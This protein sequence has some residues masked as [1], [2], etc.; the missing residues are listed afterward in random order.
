MSIVDRLF[1]GRVIKDYGVLEERSIGIGKIRQSALLVER[2]GRL[3]F[4]LKYT[5]W[6]FLSA[7]VSYH[8]LSLEN[9]AK[10]REYIA[11]SEQIAHNLPPS[12]YDANKSAIRASLLVFLIAAALLLLVKGDGSYF[13]ITFFA[14]AI[15][16]GVYATFADHPQATA[17][18]KR[19]LVVM[20]VLTFA[21]GLAKLLWLNSATLIRV[22]W[23]L[24][25]YRQHGTNP[26]QGP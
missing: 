10:L 24:N 9:A 11:D 5:A 12:T 15:Q 25:Y 8:D 17:N 3:R 20:G 7:S 19:L 1:V 14:C 16:L 4:V 26:P 21:A 18:T 2:Q 23:V 13:P 22:I 6:A